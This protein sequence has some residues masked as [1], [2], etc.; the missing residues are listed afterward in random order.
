MQDCST[1]FEFLPI[2]VSLGRCLRYCEVYEGSS[3]QQIIPQGIHIVDSQNRGEV[4][5]LYTRKRANPT[6]SFSTTA[7]FSFATGANSSQVCTGFA[8]LIGTGIHGT[9]VFSSVASGIDAN[10]LSG[11]NVLF[12][13]ASAK[14]TIDSEL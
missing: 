7:N 1:D 12:F 13:N 3:Q 8:T 9:L 6:L 4:S 2:D 5:L 11:I 10:S 14:I